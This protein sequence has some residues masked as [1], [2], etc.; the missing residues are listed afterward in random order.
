MSSPSLQAFLVNVLF[1]RQILLI[2][3]DFNL[4]GMHA[5]FCDKAW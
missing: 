4:P 2:R 5:L 1:L 3:I